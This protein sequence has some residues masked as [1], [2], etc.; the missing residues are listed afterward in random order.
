MPAATTAVDP[1]RTDVSHPMPTGAINIPEL[2][3]VRLR[4]FH[5]DDLDGIVSLWSEVRTWQGDS[6]YALGEVLTSCQKDFAVVAV[7]DEQ[8]IGAVVARAAHTQGWVMFLGTRESYH[9][10]GIG[11]ALLAAVEARMTPLGLAK[12][13]ALVPESAARVG[14]FTHRGYVAQKNLQYFERQMPI[15]RKEIDVLHRLGGRILPPGAWDKIAGMDAEKRLLEKRLVVPL[16]QP[17]LAAQFGVAPPHAIVLFG[18]PGTGKTTFARA[19][20]SRLEWAFIEVFP[21]RL[22]GA[23]GGLA[24]ALRETFLNV[25]E[26]EHAV[27]FIDEVE[28]IAARRNDDRPL[29]AHAV[30]NELLKIIPAFRDQPGRL[31]ICATNH[32]R[33]LDPAFL[34]HGRFDYVV[35][36]GLPDAVARRSIWGR[37]IPPDILESIDVEELVSLSQGFSP[38]DIEFAARKTAQ[39]ALEKA[40]DTGVSQTHGHF[41]TTGDYVD[42]IESTT[43]T[44][45]AETARS[46][47]D[48]IREFGRV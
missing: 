7:I 14:S 11:S 3:S 26:L 48:D 1:R 22:S 32:V 18:P 39:E 40:I 17:D 42:A 2:R 5:I 20:A 35:P 31:L 19:V 28:E 25:T 47:E 45:S 15:Q 33:M 6:V 24:G 46:F 34:R 10:R 30:T 38:A 27:V 13:S 4:D 29:A 23:S 12:L 44:V 36:I 37:Y 16:S 21:S 9:G 41:A 8:V 43:A